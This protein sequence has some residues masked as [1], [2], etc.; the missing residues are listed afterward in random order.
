MRKIIQIVSIPVF[1][2]LFFSCSKAEEPALTPLGAKEISGETLWN[3]ITADSDYTQYSYWPG[4]EGLQP[5]QS[6][7]GLYHRIFVN[8][9]LMEALPVNG[10]TAPDGTI[11]VKENYTSSK[12][13]ASIT[14][15]AKADG[16]D[17]ENND[18]FWAKY[19]PNGDIQAQGSPKGCILCHEGMK[20]NDYIIVRPLDEPVK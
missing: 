1:I 12:E 20:N 19:A 4:H 10:N 6:P 8:R 18:W 2:L 13:L 9:A 5:G 11:V 3:R 16:Y 7:H 14:V 17:K 15:M